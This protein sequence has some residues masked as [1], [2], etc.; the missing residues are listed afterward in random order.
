MSNLLL[1]RLLPALLVV[2][3]ASTAVLAQRAAPFGAGTPAPA[4]TPQAPIPPAGNAR[5]GRPGPGGALYIAGDGFSLEQAID[6]GIRENGG[7]ASFAVLVLGAEI[8]KLGI[9][10]TTAEIS[11]NI[12]KASNG[13][14]TLYLCERDVKRQGFA[15]HEFLPGVQI[16]RGFSKTEAAGSPPPQ[17]GGPPL[18]PIFRMRSICAD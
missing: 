17:P 3:F 9:H 5:A 14:G 8:S 16:V 2:G 18:A 7:K 13:G 6:D 4:A 11:A 1:K 15:V 12:A 10:G